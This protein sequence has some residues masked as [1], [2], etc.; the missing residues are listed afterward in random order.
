MS[1]AKEQLELEKKWTEFYLVGKRGKEGLEA[2]MA[3][4]Y[5]SLV[6]TIKERLYK[7]DNTLLFEKLTLPVMELLKFG[8]HK[9]L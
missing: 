5:E 3:R 4:S 8:L 9:E 2:I 7:T 6:L 1:Y